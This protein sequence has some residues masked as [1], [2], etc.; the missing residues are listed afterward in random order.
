MIGWAGMLVWSLGVLAQDPVYSQF[1]MAPLQLNPAFTGST[2]A[3]KFS[4]NYRNQWP[5]LNHAYTTY[6]A[7][8][9]QF[10]K[11]FNSGLGASILADDA[12]NGLIKTTKIS[13]FYAYRVQISRDFYSKFVVQASYVQSAYNWEK[14]IFP[15]QIDPVTGPISPGGTPWPT[16]ETVPPDLR[17][18]Y[19]D[20]SFGLLAYTSTWYGGLSVE[21][22]NRPSQ[23]LIAGY[24]NNID[25]LPV[26]I[27]LHAGGEVGLFEHAGWL[28]RIYISPQVMVS[29]QGPFNQLLGG[30]FFGFD[31][32]FL[33]VWGRITS[34]NPD[35]AILSAG[36]RTGILKLAYSY[37]LTVSRL[38]LGTGGTHEI[39]ILLNLDKLYPEES[40]YMDC[41]QMFR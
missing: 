20:V 30:A 31:P 5:S 18:Q 22:I 34:Q 29:R 12:G 15:D 19:L 23:I 10:F 24:E 8:Y 41:F 4:M 1:Y 9:D 27:S 21:H 38:G 40:K 17:N 11:D 25:G 26:R 39:G 28:D 32:F 7:S 14:F 16:D 2:H 6:S 37:D 33:G 35:A 3:P 13:G 36:M